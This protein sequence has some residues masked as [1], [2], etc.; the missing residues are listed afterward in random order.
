MEKR[1]KMFLCNAPYTDLVVYP[2]GDFTFC[3]YIIPIGNLKD[4]Q[5]NFSNYWNS[6]ESK[7]RRESLFDCACNHPCNLGFNIADNPK[8]NTLLPKFA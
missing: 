8:L 6:S 5:F 4:Y 2:N 1:K 7:I 3:E